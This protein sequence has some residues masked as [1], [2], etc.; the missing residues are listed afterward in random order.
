ML[1]EL[2]EYQSLV[3]RQR[4]EPLQVISG[5]ETQN[6]YQVLDAAGQEV[7]L[8]YEE[9]GFMARQFL[10]SHRPLTINIIN[11]EG[12]LLMVARRKFYWFFSHLEFF[13]PAGEFLGRL[14]R[15]FSIMGR[16]FELLDNKGIVG[17][18]QGPVLRPNT[19]WIRRDGREIA[20]I[21]K[22]WSGFAREMFT[23]ADTFQ[24]QFTDPGLVESVR[25]LVLGTALAIDLDFFERRNLRSGM[26]P[27]TMGGHSADTGGFTGRG[28]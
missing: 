1:A 17:E 16:R 6:R 10:R 12:S 9:S 14:D 19:F 28:F 21:T 8:A 3:V 18:I 5:L 25:W 7:C 2:A 20:R 15:R 26:R 27:G 22:Q 23:V 24:V 4:V 11:G 13:S